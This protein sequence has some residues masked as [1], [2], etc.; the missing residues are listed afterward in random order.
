LLHVTA[1]LVLMIV[2]RQIRPLEFASEIRSGAQAAFGTLKLALKV[3]IPAILIM[4]LGLTV[5][6]LVMDHVTANSPSQA[7]KMMVEAISQP[8]TVAATRPA[9]TPPAIAVHY[10]KM[11]AGAA[12]S[13]LVVLGLLLTASKRKVGTGIAVGSALLALA[14]IAAKAYFVFDQD[15]WN[16]HQAFASCCVAV[17]ILADLVLLIAA[18]T[19]V[20]KRP[21]T[22]ESLVELKVAT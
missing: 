22:A 10:W 9:A 4:L 12:V 18:L 5:V 2:V 13:L 15:K 3:Q 6:Q 19:F 1:F 8:S 20:F 14:A 21:S 11:I 7:T 17:S 16:T